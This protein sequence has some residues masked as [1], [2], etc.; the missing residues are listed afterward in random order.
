MLKSAKPFTSWHSVHSSTNELD[1]LVQ[2]GPTAQYLPALREWGTHVICECKF[3]KDY[4]TVT[5]VD[6]LN[7]VL[8][9]HGAS[10][11]ILMSSRG[12]TNRGK[13]A[14]AKISVRLY[15][16]MTP[17]RVIISFDLED[18][19]ACATGA[20]FLQLLSQRYV[21]ARTGADRLRLIQ[22]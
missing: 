3:S 4:V 12:M 16:A 15:S 17:S 21:E 20:N 5:W 8:Q 9:K 7:S 13:G 19:R 2:M 22:T 1:W 10:V 18:I 11:G 6:K 14:A